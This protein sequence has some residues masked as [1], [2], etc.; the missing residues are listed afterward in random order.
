MTIELNAAYRM[1]LP[2]VSGFGALQHPQV[3]ASFCAKSKIIAHHNLLGSKLQMQEF[4]HEGPGAHAGQRCSKPQNAELINAQA[5]Q[6]L[7][8]VPQSLD[9]SGRLCWREKSL[10][11]RLKRH[12]RADQ[13]L[14]LGQRLGFRDQGLMAKVNPIEI[15]DRYGPA[16]RGWQMR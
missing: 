1:D 8:L 10:G 11:M 6:G 5:G 9:F 16:L 15:S 3:A 12:D 13:A 14:L 2:V 7:G 4:V